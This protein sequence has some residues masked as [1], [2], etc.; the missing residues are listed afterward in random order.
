MALSEFLKKFAEQGLLVM[1]RTYGTFFSLILESSHTAV[2]LVLI[3]VLMCWLN[4]QVRVVCKCLSITT[5]L[6]K[7]SKM[8]VIISA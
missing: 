2:Y 6:L 7:I 1:H 5:I 3:F 8:A 4:R